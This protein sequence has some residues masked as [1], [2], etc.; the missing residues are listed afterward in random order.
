MKFRYSPGSW[1]RYGHVMALLGQGFL[2]A[3]SGNDAADARSNDLLLLCERRDANNVG[4]ANARLHESGGALSGG[5]MVED[6][7]SVAGGL[8]ATAVSLRLTHSK[9]GSK[10]MKRVKVMWLMLRG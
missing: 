5:R 1:P 8:I 7:S 10:F 4:I 2:L 3:I 9:G 6:S